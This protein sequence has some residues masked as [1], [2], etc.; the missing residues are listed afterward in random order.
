[1]GSQ[2]VGH[3]WVTYIHTHTHTH[4]MKSPGA[5]YTEKE[6]LILKFIIQGTLNSKS[7]FEK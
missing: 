3:N 4:T 1:M 7:N 2:R 6:K 5:F